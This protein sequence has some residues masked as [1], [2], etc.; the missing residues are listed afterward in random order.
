MPPYDKL[1]EGDVGTFDDAICAGFINHLEGTELDF[2]G[3][4]C[5]WDNGQ[6]GTHD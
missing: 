1:R 3:P 4:I 6:I 2:Q 5:T